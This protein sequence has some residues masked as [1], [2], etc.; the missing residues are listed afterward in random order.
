MLNLEEI[1]FQPAVIKRFRLEEKG[2]RKRKTREGGAGAKAGVR[3]G[4]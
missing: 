2:E 3:A 4:R 1:N